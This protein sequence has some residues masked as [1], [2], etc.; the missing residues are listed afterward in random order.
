MGFLNGSPL[1][2]WNAAR[3]A[4]VECQVQSED[5]F[6]ER[7]NNFLRGKGVATFLY[8]A[9]PTLPVRV[10]KTFAVLKDWQTP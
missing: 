8:N 2:L 3:F 7:E 9:C 6:G 5:F 10:L 4:R 1:N